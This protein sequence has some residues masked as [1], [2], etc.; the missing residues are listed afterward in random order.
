MQTAKTT[1]VNMNNQDDAD[2]VMK[3]IESVWGITRAE[4]NLSKGEALFTFDEKM[5]SEEDFKQAIIDSG[6][7]ITTS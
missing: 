1:I 3:V 5:A 6:Y 7:Q 4:V 2:K